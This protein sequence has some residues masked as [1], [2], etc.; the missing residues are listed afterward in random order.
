M[1]V[2]LAV[3][4]HLLF[5]RNNSMSNSN[6]TGFYVYVH[7]REDDGKIFYVGK[8]SGKRS[9]RRCNRNQYWK[10]VVA[11]HGL[12]VE[13]VYHANSEDDAFSEERFL[14]SS[15][16]I[17]TPSITNM[18]NGGGGICGYSHSDV[19]KN[20]ISKKNKGMKGYWS[21]KKR[22][23]EVVKKTADS[24]RGKKRSAESIKKMSQSKIGK[25][26]SEEVVKKM[27][28]RMSR[29][30]GDL[31]PRK[32]SVVCVE[33]GMVFTTAK[34]AVEWLKNNGHPKASHSAISMAC[35]GI[36]KVAYGFSWLFFKNYSSDV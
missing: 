30:T 7:R 16:K 5:S 12:K 33:N 22:S 3:T 4:S 10:N 32:K 8:G 26:L 35:H 28:E 36:Y 27:S 15:L 25:K 19:A 31:S 17:F 24:N 29:M 2:H 18:T 13:I 14:T 1:V 6:S 20:Q 34:S 21:G 9:H 23:E 11:K